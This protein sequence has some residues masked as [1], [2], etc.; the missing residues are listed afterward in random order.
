MTARL[1]PQPLGYSMPQARA[2]YQRLTETLEALPGVDAVSM[3]NELQIGA[4]YARIKLTVED[5]P[6][7]G[8]M[9]TETSMIAP[10]YFETV[11]VRLISGRDLRPPTTARHAS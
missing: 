9:Q 1:D 2:L 10:R 5:A 3:A 11:G 4:G 8:P 6:G 7:A